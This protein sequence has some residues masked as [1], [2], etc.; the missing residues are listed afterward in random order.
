MGNILLIVSLGY[1]WSKTQHKLAT[2]LATNKQKQNTQ[3]LSFFSFKCGL[4]WKIFK[5]T[6][7]AY[8]RKSYNM[9]IEQGIFVFEAQGRFF[10]L[11]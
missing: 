7:H 2:E 5:N 10:S 4:M 11:I 6:K 9:Q 1:L 3:P 8:T